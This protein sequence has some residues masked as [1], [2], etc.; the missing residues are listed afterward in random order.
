MIKG[1]II[2]GKFGELCIR[3]KSNA[4]IQLGELL[5]AESGKSKILLQVYDLLY[6][7]QM[8]QQN[9]ELI[10]GMSLEEDDKAEFFEPALRN[11]MLAFAKPLIDISNNNVL[12]NI[13][14]KE[15][16]LSKSLPDFFSSV[17]QVTK[18]DLTFLTQPKNPLYIGKLRSGSE[19]L[20][21]DI[22]LNGESVFSHH[23]LI[24]ATT[25]KGKSNL[26]SCMLWSCIDKDYCGMLV[27]DP[28]DE[29]YG[30]SGL[31]IKN[32]P[33]REK[34][35]YYSTSPPAGCR[36]LKINIKSIKP[37]HFNGVIDLSDPQKQAMQ[38]YYRKFGERW[39]EA[40]LLDKKID[41][42]FHEG[43]MA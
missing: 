31:G 11:Y 17:R 3:Q 28:H 36:T 7:S 6:G 41:M 39:V 19:L 21:V 5:I 32:H 22:F 16:R 38:A 29:Y 40:A 42:Q 26:M 34:V 23:I 33:K 2:S 1:Q 4:K 9:L 18:E 13:S 15:A 43:T 14:S 20:D 12:G 25:G 8:S 37:A 24:P 30:N 10:S 27:L 35:V